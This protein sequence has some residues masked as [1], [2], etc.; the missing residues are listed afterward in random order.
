MLRKFLM[1]AL[2]RV[3]CSAGLD[4]VANSED[5]IYKRGERGA[6]RKD[7]QDAHQ[8]QHENDRQQPELFVLA[9][10]EPEL[11]DDCKFTHR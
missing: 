11:A 6:L 5:R 8:K 3:T 7:Q 2:Y 10:K 9:Q 4:Q 1:R